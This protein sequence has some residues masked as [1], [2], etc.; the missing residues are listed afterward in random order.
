M[1][2]LITL[3]FLLLA[4]P[5][6]AQSGK[7]EVGASVNLPVFNSEDLAAE[8][9]TIETQG[10]VGFGVTVNRYWTERLST[11]LAYSTLNGDVHIEDILED[12]ST[13]VGTTDL[14]VFSATAQWHP[15]VDSRLDAYIGA[16][17]AHVTGEVD[18]VDEIGDVSVDLESQ[19]GL[20]AN[21]GFF[22]RVTDRFSIGADVKYIPFE[23]LPEDADAEDLDDEIALDPLVFSVGVKFRF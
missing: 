18:L 13:K 7:T 9:I 12:T 4:V 2:K 23:A 16:G 17:V 5:S 14:R 6:F 10:E 21:A 8:L 19:T 11:E 20:L 22:V 1:K 15:L 3:L